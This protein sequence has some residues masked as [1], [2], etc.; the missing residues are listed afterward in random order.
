M[1]SLCFFGSSVF[2]LGSIDCRK[3]NI[4]LPLKK[5]GNNNCA[6]KE[7]KLFILFEKTNK[8]QKKVKLATL[9]LRTVNAFV[10]N[11]H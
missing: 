7:R 3:K 1:G 5:I 6:I 10:K 4:Y 2:S 8:F 11:L 9:Q